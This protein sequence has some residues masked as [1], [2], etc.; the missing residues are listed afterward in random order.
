M[1]I[2]KEKFDINLKFYFFLKYIVKINFS[3]KQ[4]SSILE[5]LPSVKNSTETIREHIAS[6][7]NTQTKG[8]STIQLFQSNS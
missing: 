5:L 8:Y 2:D 7:I 3:E 6:F 1:K 4:I